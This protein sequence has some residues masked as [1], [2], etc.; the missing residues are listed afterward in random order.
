MACWTERPA[1]WVEAPDGSQVSPLMRAEGRGSLALF[2]LLP[3]QVSRAKQ[4]RTVH[5]LW[6]VVG[7]S[8]EM[9]VGEEGP[10]ALHPG[11]AVEIA[12]R[13]RFQFV[14]GQDGLEVVGVTMPPWPLDPSVV[15]A[16]DAPAQWPV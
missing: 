13:T 9:V 11:I 4:H 5:E 16:V 2:R 1:D 7:G 3:A 15:E 6:Y 10:F 14:A 12:P 8:G